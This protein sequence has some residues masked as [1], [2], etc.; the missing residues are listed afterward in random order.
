MKKYLASHLIIRLGILF[1][2]GVAA[3]VLQADISKSLQRSSLIQ[4]WDREQ[5][6]KQSTLPPPAHSLGLNQNFFPVESELPVPLPSSNTE[7][8]RME[9][10]DGKPDEDIKGQPRKAMRVVEENHVTR[11]KTSADVQERQNL[12]TPSSWYMAPTAPSFAAKASP[13]EGKLLI[14]QAKPSSPIAIESKPGL[15]LNPDDKSQP[16]LIRFNNVSIIEYLRF[17]SGISHK[18][19]IFDENDLQFNITMISEEPTS[20]DDFMTALLQE[21]RIHDLTLLEQ[22]NNLVIHKNLK[23]NNVSTVV[24]DESGDKKTS[25]ELVTQ[26]FRLNTADAEKVATIVRPLISERALVEVI[27]DT[28]HLILTDLTSNVIEIGKLIRSIDSP[29]GGLVIGQYVVRTSTID[30][31]LP[32]VQQ[33][34]GPISAEQ[35]IQYVPYTSVNSIF[36]VSTPFLVEKALSI[37]QHLDQSQ[38]STT[39]LDL[40]DLKYQEPRSTE[41]PDG[42]VQSAPPIPSAGIFVNG[43]P[44]EPAPI[45]ATPALPIGG[46]S[47]DE[48]LQ[49]A[50]SSTID[51][52]A[53]SGWK[54]DN[55]GNW[56]FKV[57]TQPSHEV[58]P[59]RPPSGK[60][61]ID[62]KGNWTFL[63]G[64]IPTASEEQNQPRGHWEVDPAGN[65][66]FDLEK[67]ETISI[68]V[69]SRFAPE[70]EELLPGSK[71]KGQFFLHKVHYRKGEELQR[72]FQAMSDS[73]RE[74][75]NIDPELVNALGSV[76]W[77]ESSNSL[78]FSGTPEA[79]E[80]I[81][82]LVNE[83]DTP[84]RQVFIEMLILEAT[85]VD[86]LNYGVKWGNRFGGGNWAGADGWN[87]NPP[88]ALSSALDSTGINNLGQPIQISPTSGLPILGQVL[89]PNPIPFNGTPGFDIGVIG[90]RIFNKLTGIEFESMGAFINCL[91]AIT[92]ANIVLNPK[93]ITEDGVPAE[94][95]VGENIAY[96]TQSIVNDQGQIL[97]SNFEYRDVGARLKVTPYLGA[98]DIIA[99]EIENEITNVIT[100]AQ[101]GIPINSNAGPST[102]KSST[103]TRVH[104]PSGFFLVISGMLRDET[105]RADA[106]APCLGGI[107]ILGAAFK[108]KKY[109]DQKRNLMI[110]IQPRIIDTDADIQNLTKHQQDILKVKNRRKKDMLYETEEFMDFLNLKKYEHERT[111]IEF[112]DDEEPL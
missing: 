102:S 56:T 30:S 111:S 62:M 14:S 8:K 59:A 54:I 18:N 27:K 4:D 32:I 48:P 94:I 12:S 21:L 10:N 26:V 19:F 49:R 16:I 22:G 77:L 41:T 40:K 103:V 28:N 109:E 13:E 2:T 84:L 52:Q 67:G 61:T 35:S 58:D 88:S 87:A 80:K 24:T 93:I 31:I 37:L 57:L 43:S 90:Q 38:K 81:S 98:S 25:F 79:L 66:G 5:S 33:L 68:N 17:I 96:Q 73:I 92:T 69:I 83:I 3:Q 45:S 23:V 89:I 110:F 36:I 20:I 51:T 101:A 72:S 82:L 74:T 29:T 70:R 46:E 105:R 78:I 97:T 99:L 47:R 11:E 63:P 65:W 86:A 104:I 60:W 1:T 112:D 39:I 100:N 75:E 71:P 53:N 15:P 91:R 42:R 6:A 9:A 50:P 7:T 108:D 85:L 44:F 95:F 106:H 107:P 34:M 76:Q 64:A 55:H